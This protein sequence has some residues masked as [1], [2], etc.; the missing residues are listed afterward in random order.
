MSITYVLGSTPKWAQENPP[1]GNYPY[2]GTG[3]ANPD[4]DVWKKWVKTVV[5]RYGASIDAYQIWNEANL[6]DF[7]DGTPKQ[8]AK[9]TKEFQRVDKDADGEACLI[10]VELCPCYTRLLH[11]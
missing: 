11:V 3:S 7:Y 2:G 5:Q 6:S 8:M 1:K 4:K 10:T 9:L